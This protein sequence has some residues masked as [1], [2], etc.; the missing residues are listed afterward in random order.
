MTIKHGIDIKA[1]IG[2]KTIK[3]ILLPVP[4][5]Y[6]WNIQK[7]TQCNCLLTAKAYKLPLYIFNTTTDIQPY[8]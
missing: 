8:K 1:T 2:K 5:T 7:N 6:A 3:F 4:K